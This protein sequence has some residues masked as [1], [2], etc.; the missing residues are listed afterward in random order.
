MAVFSLNY[1]LVG[2]SIKKANKTVSYLDEYIKDMNSVVKDCENLNGSD[3][4]GYVRTATDLV[5][6]KIQKAK[7]E[8]D[9]YA[10]FSKQMQTLEDFAREKDSAVEKNIDVTVSNYVGQRTIGQKI[11]DWIYSCYIGFLD[12]VSS[13]GP[14]GKTIAQGI[15]KAGNWISETTVSIRNYFK[16]GEGKY[17]WN[18]ITALGEVLEATGLLIATAAAAVTAA[19]ALATMA[20]IGAIAAGVYLCMKMVDASIAI[21]QNM[22]ALDLE[23]KYQKSVEGKTEENWWETEN[24]EGSLTGA[25]Y[26]GG[27]KG[28]KDWVEKTDF[29]GTEENGRMDVIGKTYEVVKFAMKITAA[30]CQVRVSLGNAQYLKGVD[31]EWIRNADGD[32]IKKSGTFLQNVRTSYLE[33]CGYHLR[34]YKSGKMT[35]VH[36]NNIFKQKF[37]AKKAFLQNP[38][39]GYKKNFLELGLGVTQSEKVFLTILNGQKIAKTAD[40]MVSDVKTIN[41]WWKGDTTGLAEANKVGKAG[42]NLMQKAP[43]TSFFNTFT[44]DATKSFGVL[45]ETVDKIKTTFSPP[46]NAYKAYLEA[47]KASGGGSFIDGSSGNAGGGGGGRAF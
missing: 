17:I 9:N 2:D 11:G 27:T 4:K 20:A 7:E 44:A 33:K 30:V 5:K 34:R 23:R 47:I 46:E 8:R 28:F 45:T 15:R 18:S 31:G 14:V 41:D 22:D 35:L 39:K 10:S 36:E 32:V 12:C 26:Y 42:M 3:S 19:P 16:Y 6:K 29:G 1:S 24:D 38:F 21:D 43:I 25:R 13:L 37:D 40:G